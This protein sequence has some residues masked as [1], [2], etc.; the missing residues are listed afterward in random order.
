MAK[1]ASGTATAPRKR[2]KRSNGS[3][4]K[5]LEKEQLLLDIPVVYGGVSIGDKTA[6]LG[7][8]IDR[9]DMDIAKADEL[10]VD[11]RLSGRVVLGHSDES[12]EQ[13]R[14]FEDVD[15]QVSGSCDV[16]GFRVG[17]TAFATALTFSLKD[18]EISEL[19]KFSKGRGRL[20]VTGS[21]EIPDG[22]DGDEFEGVNEDD[23][24]EEA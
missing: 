18:I 1:K 24:S 15:H 13:T 11:R 7:I 6:R 17:S 10:L 3:A 4:P 16:K 23:E 21:R 19:A 9:G 22:E 12:A 14:L 2:A 5:Q 8:R 20:A